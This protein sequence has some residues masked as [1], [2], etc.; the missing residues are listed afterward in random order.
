MCV[1][2]SDNGGAG[3]YDEVV[4]GGCQTVERTR[5]E[6]NYIPP[7]HEAAPHPIHPDGQR[8]QQGYDAQHR[9]RDAWALVL[10]LLGLAKSERTKQAPTGQLRYDSMNSLEFG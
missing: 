9:Y 10:L 7:S 3:S 6:A 5:W 1:R 4:S 8:T 2:A